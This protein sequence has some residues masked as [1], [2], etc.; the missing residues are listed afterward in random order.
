[1]TGSKVG[2]T[3]LLTVPQFSQEHSPVCIPEGSFNANDSP[4]EGTFLDK[5]ILMD[6]AR[7]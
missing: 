5:E 3:P 7:N 4:S 1:M 2:M 6:P